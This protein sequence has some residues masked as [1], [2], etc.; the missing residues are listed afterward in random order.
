MYGWR[1][2]NTLTDGLGYPRDAAHPVMGFDPPALCTILAFHTLELPRDPVGR[3]HNLQHSAEVGVWGP[4]CRRSRDRGLADAA[5]GAMLPNVMHGISR[6]MKTA[7]H[8]E[9]VKRG[10]PES[11]PR[12]LIN[13]NKSRS[14]ISSKENN[15]H[16]ARLG[17]YAHTN[18]SGTRDTRLSKS[19]DSNKAGGS[20]SRHIKYLFITRQ[21]S[22]LKNDSTLFPLLISV[23]VQSAEIPSAPSRQLAFYYPN[24]DKE[25]V[26]SKLTS[27]TPETSPK[28]RVFTSSD[29]HQLS[30]DLMLGRL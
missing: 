16:T 26:P 17:E 24:E 9:R 23:F 29:D 7:L 28:L 2:L 21:D 22:A 19:R 6:E 12:G 27:I 14:E 15:A 25:R 4:C 11:T 1:A 5:A 10:V 18:T 8:I 30:G 3:T 20:A 13:Q